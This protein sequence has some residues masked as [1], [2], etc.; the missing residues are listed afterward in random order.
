MDWRYIVYPAL[1]L[2][3]LWVGPYVG[4]FFERRNLSGQADVDA[5]R[6]DRRL[7]RLCGFG[8]LVILMVV[9]WNSFG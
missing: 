8:G 5:R 6:R 4:V 7:L 3:L 1:L 9:V 2:L